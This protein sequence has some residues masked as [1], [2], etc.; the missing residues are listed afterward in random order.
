M[1]DPLYTINVVAHRLFG[2]QY[3]EVEPRIERSTG[4]SI[5]NHLRIEPMFRRRAIRAFPDYD[6][7]TTRSETDVRALFA[8]ET[9]YEYP[10]DLTL[11]DIFE[12]LGVQ[13]RL[14]RVGDEVIDSHLADLAATRSDAMEDIAR[15]HNER[16]ALN[17]YFVR[18]IRGAYGTARYYSRHQQHPTFAFVA[19][20]PYQPFARS[21]RTVA[22]ELGHVLGLPHMPSLENLMAGIGADSRSLNF[23]PPQIHVARHHASMMAAPSSIP[24]DDDLRWVLPHPD[25]YRDWDFTLDEEEE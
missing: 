10:G 3:R 4:R 21:L 11:N 19:D 1:P 24:V 16:Y 13:F 20:N 6:H 9:G 15:Q 17:V 14:L 23:E 8:R 22:H 5:S 7:G 2:T 25:L 18:D 12:P